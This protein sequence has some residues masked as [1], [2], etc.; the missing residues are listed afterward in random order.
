[1]TKNRYLE[2]NLNNSRWRLYVC[3]SKSMKFF[4]CWHLQLWI[5]KA[6]V[7]FLLFYLYC[8]KN[9]TQFWAYYKSNIFIIFSPCIFKNKNIV[10]SV[11]EYYFVHIKLWDFRLILSL[12]VK[13]SSKILHQLQIKKKINRWNSIRKKCTSNPDFPCNKFYQEIKISNRQTPLHLTCKLS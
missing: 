12:T 3:V 7:S 5:N 13:F 6:L 2:N 4:E 10:R 9:S 11:L 1:M 8:P